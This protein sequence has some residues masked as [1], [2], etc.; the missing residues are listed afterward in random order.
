MIGENPCSP[1]K[2]KIGEILNSI[3]LI[4]NMKE[5]SKGHLSLTLCEYVPKLAIVHHA[6]NMES[7]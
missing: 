5:N 1:P 4:T 3:A 7:K 6:A 2:M